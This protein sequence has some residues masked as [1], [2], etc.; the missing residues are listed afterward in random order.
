MIVS[1]KHSYA[2]PKFVYDIRSWSRCH[3]QILELRNY[4]KITH[5]GW[6]KIVMGLGTANQSALF[7]CS[8]VM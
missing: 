8:M 1:A 5:S 7:Q 6:L 4:A 2:V 3:K